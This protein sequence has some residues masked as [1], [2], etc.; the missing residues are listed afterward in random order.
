MKYRIAIG[1]K[2]FEI[3]VGKIDAGIAQVNV[4]GKDYEVDIENYAEVAFGSGRIHMAP[5]MVADAVMSPAPAPGAAPQP[6]AG[7]G[8]APVAA[9]INAP[10]AAPAVAAPAG[11]GAVVAPIP[12]LILDVKVKVGDTVTAGQTVATMEA[13]KMENNIV[14]NDGGTVEEIRV[15]K[16]AEVATGDVIMMVA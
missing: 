4:D 2:K 6:P 16:G 3:E 12:G 11:A 10:A 14:T 8:A 1:E 7:G 9:R 5:A 15:Q 13:M